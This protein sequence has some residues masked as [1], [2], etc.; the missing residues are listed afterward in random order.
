[1]KKTIYLLAAMLVIQLHLA[2]QTKNKIRFSNI[3]QAGFI[4]G[5]STNSL[6]LQTINGI[7]YKTLSLGAGAGI[8]YYYFKTIPL[9]IDVRKNILDK[10]ETPFVY[11]DL[12]T[13]L[14][15]DRSRTESQWQKSTYYNGIFYDF[16]LGYKWT[17]KGSFALNFSLGYSQKHV[18]EAQE[19]NFW[20]WIDFPTIRPGG[21]N[22]D[23]YHF[24]YTFRRF[25]F[26]TGLS[27]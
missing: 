19:T 27:F 2:A 24:D 20:A 12:G 23:T 26:K 15:W 5:G 16:G 18:K 8:D 4:A 1:M 6:L 25:S 11:L 14:P 7:S 13:N 10:K 9:F 3:S 21:D 17:F 22:I